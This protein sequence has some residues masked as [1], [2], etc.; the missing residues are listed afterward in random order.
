MNESVAFDSGDTATIAS[1]MKVITK[2]GRVVISDGHLGLL[3]ENG[4]L[5]DSAPMSAVLLKKGLTY[6]MVPTLH[7][8]L[9]GSKYLVN[10][11]YQARI[12]AGQDDATAKDAQRSENVGFVDVVRRLG[13]QVKGL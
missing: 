9:N 4:D 11:S 1:G 7:V 5:I 12:E 3:R 8:V 2:L 6:S 13:G 10:L